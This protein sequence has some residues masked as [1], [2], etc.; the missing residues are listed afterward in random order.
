MK[1]ALLTATYDSRNGDKRHKDWLKLQQRKGKGK[2]N[3][4]NTNMPSSS[5]FKT[6]GFKIQT[7]DIRNPTTRAFMV[8]SQFGYFAR[9]LSVMEVN[10]IAILLSLRKYK[11]TRRL[12]Q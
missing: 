12:G 9:Q 4:K 7:R 3:N 5:I 11:N 2:Y 1:E 10:L 8:K 6:T